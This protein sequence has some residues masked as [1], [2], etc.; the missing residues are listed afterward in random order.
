MS[1]ITSAAPKLLLTGVND[2]SGQPNVREPEQIPTHLVHGHIYAE[3]G[4]TTPQL[5]V[6][7]ARQTI[8][9]AKTFDP[10][11]PYYNH[12][13]ELLANVIG[14]GSACFIQRLKPIDANP[15][16]RLLLSLDIVPDAI[17]QYQRNEDGSFLLDAQGAK[18]PITDSG[19]TIAG[20]RARW[21]L[22][23]IPAVSN[24]S[25]SFTISG[26]S[27]PANFGEVPS[28]VGTLVSGTQ[29]QS[30]VYPILELE[31]NFFGARGN[32]LGLRITA[33]TTISNAPINDTVFNAIKSYLYR[34]SLVNRL[35]IDSTVNV[36]QTLTGEQAIDFTFKSNTVDTTTDT[37]VSLVDI[38]MKAYQ[39][40][41][42]KGVTPLYGPFGKV[43][44]YE[45]NLA[46]ILTMIGTIEAPLGTLPVETMDENSDWLHAV[47]ILTGTNHFGV[48]YYSYELQGLRFTDATAVWATGG[49][50]GTMT[51]AAHDALVRNEMLNYGQTGADLLDDAKYPFS[52]YYDSGYT[53]NTKLALLTPLGLRKDIGV[54]LSTQDVSL[55][56]NTPSVDSSMAASLRNAARL[57]PE[58][59]IHGTPVCR[60][61]VVAHSGELIGSKYK[62]VSGRKHLPFTIE[63][64]G[65]AARYM[66][67]GT[68]IWDPNAAF[69]MP[70]NNQIEKFKNT[71]V[72]FK[73]AGAE[74]RDWDNGVV[75]AKTYD[76]ESIY[77]PGI[78][79]V[80]D[81]DTSIL[82]SFFNMAIA[83]DLEKVAQRAY[84][85]LAGI[86]KLTEAQ[87]ILRSNDLI[88]ERV[89]GK[90]DGRV[91]IRPD[92]YFTVADRQRGYSWKTDIH[93]YGQNMLTVG[94]YTVVSHRSTELQ[95]AA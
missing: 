3:W 28:K 68:G 40:T 33:P 79:T 83:I 70:P 43:K 92:T 26:N 7:G 45:D 73:T 49:S 66:G 11:Y 86:S 65:K 80:Y 14:E 56:Q 72:V 19:A 25:S 34:L 67:A 16:A 59:E 95:L 54:I 20:H 75:G 21:V 42:T 23:D 9:G 48:P 27:A 41:D 15:P 64:A 69:D 38:F 46:L 57:Y 81:D 36:T 17:Q 2:V 90:Y 74:Q 35:D 30:I 87:F 76:M 13:T 94:T 24:P 29:V 50:D 61:V 18:I 62:G 58:S 55:V 47:N 93:M 52:Y 6:G 84:R 71:N 77:W 39:D 12:Q 60:A 10:R 53:L 85:D 22:N 44:V 63:F 31:A 78:Q 51:F 91:T 32:N 89:E 8:F 1:N 4:P 88:N 5:S 37:E 82:N